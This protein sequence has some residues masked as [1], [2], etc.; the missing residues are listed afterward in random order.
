MVIYFLRKA[1]G[2]ISGGLKVSGH[3]VYFLVNFQTSWLFDFQFLPFRQLLAKFQVHRGSGSN[4]MGR[5]SKSVCSFSIKFGNF[6]EKSRNMVDLQ[7]P[8]I[9]SKIIQSIRYFI[10][11]LIL[12]FLVC[13]LNFV[14]FGP[15][16]PILEGGGGKFP[17]PL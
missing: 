3:P 5:F 1:E 12:C 15:F 16:L 14:R 11:V 2:S 7:S 4:F 10:Y 6:A 8:L 9:G 13:V 17:P